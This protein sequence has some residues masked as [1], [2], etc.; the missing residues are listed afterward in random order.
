MSAAI[1]LD[2]WQKVRSHQVNCSHGCTRK[3]VV[4]KVGKILLARALA[5]PEKSIRPKSFPFVAKLFERIGVRI[6]GKW[7]EAVVRDRSIQSP[8]M[9]QRTDYETGTTTWRTA[10][11]KIVGYEV[12]TDDKVRHYVRPFEIK[13]LR[14]KRSGAAASIVV[15]KTSDSGSSPDF[16]ANLIIMVPA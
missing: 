16:S 15:S 9:Y 12:E 14:E 5:E 3:R 10:A 2:A 11:A 8:E 6:D 13:S 4:C 1:E 7:T